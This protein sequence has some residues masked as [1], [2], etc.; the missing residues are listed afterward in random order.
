[1][2][3]VTE[4]K[5]LCSECNR[6]LQSCALLC[7]FLVALCGLATLLILQ[8]DCNM[9]R[10]SR[11]PRGKWQVVASSATDMCIGLEHPEQSRQLHQHE[12][13]LAMIPTAAS[14]LCC[15]QLGYC[16]L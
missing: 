7:M 9:N 10:V 4:A 14:L 8:S 3:Y 12:E 15:P 13:R 5:P 2:L 16:T 11:L 6:S 1:M